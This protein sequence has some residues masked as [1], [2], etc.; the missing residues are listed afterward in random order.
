VRVQVC[1]EE[2]VM[3]DNQPSDEHERHHA[4]QAL[5]EEFVLAMTEHNRE[6]SLAFGLSPERML[7]TT[8]AHEC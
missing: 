2:L 3:E 5:L 8:A 6:G 1:H 7:I 4:E